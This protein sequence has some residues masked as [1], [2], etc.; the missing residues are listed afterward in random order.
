M[1]KFARFDA[2]QEFSTWATLVPRQMSRRYSTS[3]SV[4][5]HQKSQKLQVFG[6]AVRSYLAL[7]LD[8]PSPLC[9]LIKRNIKESSLVTW[10]A[11]R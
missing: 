5:Q 3:P 10:Q 7:S 11:T 6:N 2:A 8:I 4:L 9:N 1:Q